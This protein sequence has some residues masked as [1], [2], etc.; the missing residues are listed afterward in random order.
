MDGLPVAYTNFRFDMDYGRRVVYCY[1]LQVAHDYRRKGV[2]FSVSASCAWRAKANH[3]LKETHPFV[4]EHHGTFPS[5]PHPPRGWHTARAR[6]M[7]V[8]MSS[9]VD[10]SLTA[11]R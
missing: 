10:V 2:S 7:Q 9:V 5:S 1:Q 11:A 3:L 6:P 4:F 8:D